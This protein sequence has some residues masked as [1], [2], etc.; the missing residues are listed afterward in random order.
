MHPVPYNLAEVSVR[1]ARSMIPGGFPLHF[2]WTPHAFPRPS[3]CAFVRIYPNTSLIVAM[4]FADVHL[5]LSHGCFSSIYSLCIRFAFHP[6]HATRS[7]YS[8]SRMRAIRVEV[9][10]PKKRVR[11][12]TINVIRASSF[13]QKRFKTKWTH[14]KM[15]I[16]WVKFILG[17]PW[18]AS[19]WDSFGAP[20]FRAWSEIFPKNIADPKK[21]HR[22]N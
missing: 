4:R 3:H 5:M 11:S 17:D 18:A 10:E 7:T 2:P 14:Y 1:L 21:S 19:R 16:D 9:I 12:H 13:H 22:P 20:P 15:R 8:R 6:V